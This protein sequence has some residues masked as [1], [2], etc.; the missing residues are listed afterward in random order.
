VE[1]YFS[2]NRQQLTMQTISQNSL[3]GK[4]IRRIFG[5]LKAHFPKYSKELAVAW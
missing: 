4:A 3:R 2:L 5:I 1:K